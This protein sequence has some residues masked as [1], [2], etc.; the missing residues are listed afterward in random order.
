MLLQLPSSSHYNKQNDGN[1]AVVAY[2]DVLQQ[3]K[4]TVVLSSPSSPR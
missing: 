2:F 1:V 4:V 3:K